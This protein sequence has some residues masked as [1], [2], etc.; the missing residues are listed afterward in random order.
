[1]LYKL[2]R[3]NSITCMHAARVYIPMCHPAITSHAALILQE[4]WQALH[5]RKIAASPFPL[6][7]P[8]SPPPLASNMGGCSLLPAALLQMKTSY[9]SSK[10]RMTRSEERRS[11]R[12]MQCDYTSTTKNCLYKECEVRGLQLS[13]SSVLPL[14]CQASTSSRT[15]AK[16]LQQAFN[17]IIE[18]EQSIVLWR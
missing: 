10:Q 5:G 6:L 4:D 14:S 12:I 15:T 13:C 11:Q 7:D 1:M 8:S 2:Y 16:H 9:F 3:P 18:R 17:C